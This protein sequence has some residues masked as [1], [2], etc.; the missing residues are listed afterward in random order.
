MSKRYNNLYE[1][2]IDIDNIKLAHQHAR[3]DKGLYSAVQKTDEHLEERAKAIQKML[4]NHT[5]KVSKYNVGV[6]KDKTKERILYKLPYYPDRIIQWA[7]MLQLSPIFEKT[8]TNF[9]CASLPGRGIHYASKKL[10]KYLNTNIEET[11]YC[12]KLDIQKFYPN[13][14]HEILKNLLRKKIKDKD[15]LIELDKII[16]SMKTVSLEHLNIS[17]ELKEKSFIPGRGVPIGSY[18]SQ[19]FANFYLTYFDHWLKEQQNCKYVIRYMD[20]IVILSASKE[21]LHNL[22]K[23]I[24]SYLKENLDLEIKS[25]YQIFPV[26]D[27]G[28][29]FVGYRHFHGYKLLRKTTLKDCKKIIEACHRSPAVLPDAL[30]SAYNSYEGWLTWCDSNRIYKKY[31]NPLVPKVNT[32]Y[33]LYKKSKRKKANYS[34]KIF[35]NFKKHKQFY[36]NKNYHKKLHERNVKYNDY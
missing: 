25:N 33:F 34:Y 10:D 28:I 5:Y 32:Y 26:D 9:T 22:L 23:N 14:N 31:F 24:R 12:L 19:Y 2:I 20:D 27:R 13:I 35:N 16:D 36:M 17:S 1:K 29:D 11:K 8:F 4:K 30:W 15:L 6:L 18:L 7:I 21:Y 3:R